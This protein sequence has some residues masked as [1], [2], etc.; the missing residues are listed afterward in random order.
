MYKIYNNVHNRIIL[1][2]MFLAVNVPFLLGFQHGYKNITN[3]LVTTPFTH[4][5]FTAPS[6]D[7]TVYVTVYTI[8]PNDILLFY[9]QDTIFTAKFELTVAFKNNNDEIVKNNILQK[10]VTASTFEETNSKTIFTKNQIT[11][12]LQPGNYKLIINMLDLTTRKP[13]SIKESITVPSYYS[14]NLLST[15][16]RFY[17]KI[18]K[19]LPSE[20]DFPVF[21]AVRNISDSLLWS[22]FYLYTKD[23]ALPHKVIYTIFNVQGKNV[24][25]DSITFI[26][27]NNVKSMIYSI[28]QPFSIGKYILGAKIMNNKTS[29][30]TK[31]IFFI[32]EAGQTT[33]VASPS[34]LIKPLKYIMDKKLFT[35]LITAQ[36]QEQKKII[37]DF[38]KERD[39]D[40]ATETNEL[41]DEF[42]RR[43]NYANEHFSL[44]TGGTDGWRSD[45][46]RVYIIY[47]E[48]SQID[49]MDASRYGTSKYEVWYYSNLGRKF[50]FLDRYGNNNYI[51]V[52]EE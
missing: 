20:S 47:G 30:T 22:Q 23:P 38:W 11:F 27:K 44:Y 46:G 40:P 14:K 26:P 29:C 42:Y 45:M 16:I 3:F 36:D 52:S 7:T 18:Q 41:R 13:V 10:T 6:S 34:L 31:G 17:T 50:I 15:D 25:S 1:F 4:Y 8:I 48:P 32:K 9:Q 5:V 33:L 49:R 43:V 35:Q 28:G 12:L 19:R 2:A 51:L 21:P 24:Y 37:S 39:P